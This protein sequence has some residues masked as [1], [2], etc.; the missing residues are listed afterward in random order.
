M[1]F[2]EKQE[3]TGTYY[4]VETESGTTFLPE[5]VCG[6]LYGCE[7]G[8]MYYNPKDAA[9]HSDTEDAEFVAQWDDWCARVADYVDGHRIREISSCTGT[10]YR[11]SAPGYMDCTGWTTD[12]NSPEFDDMDE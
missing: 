7:E 3:Y 6:A 2:M 9:D 10:L 11:L 12:A 1:S 5:D 8:V 4:A